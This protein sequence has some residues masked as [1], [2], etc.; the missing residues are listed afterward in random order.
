MPAHKKPNGVKAIAKAKLDALGIDEFCSSLAS[1]KSQRQICKEIGIC[2]WDLARWLADE[3]G[4]SARARDAMAVS[5]AHWDEEAE[6][7]IRK[8]RNTP[9]SIAKA[10][11]L[12]Q[13][14]RW[15][16][17]NYAPKTYGDKVATEVTGKDGGPVQH[18][19]IDATKLTDEELD[20]ALAI[21]EKLNPS[22][23]ISKPVA[24]E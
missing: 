21:A 20:A 22:A 15:R 18:V 8:M 23:F 17:K 3:E 7:E 2:K 13:H 10:R 12:A 16:A 24:D 4:R 9:G 6:I 14:F 5:A 1:G 11:E 19:T